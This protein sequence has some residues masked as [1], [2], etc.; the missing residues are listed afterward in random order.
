M[1]RLDFLNRGEQASD[2]ALPLPRFGMGTAAIGN[3]YAPVSDEAAHAAVATALDLGVGYFDTAPYYG[4]GLA[5]RRLGEALGACGGK[6]IVSTK[7]GRLL[8]PVENPDHERH[9][10]VG[11]D[12]FQPRFDYSYDAVLRSH[13]ESLKRL[14]RQRVEILLAHDMGELTHG[15]QADRHM[16]DFLNGGYR[17][18]ADLKASGAID[19]IG[20]GVNETA[21]IEDLLGRVDL[22]V[23]LIA[24]RYTL[25]DQQAADRLFPICESKDVRVIIGGPYNSGILA[26]PNMSRTEARYDYQAAPAEVVARAE[27][28]ERVCER[29]GVPL[30][31]AALQFPSR[32]RAVDCVIAGCGSKREIKEAVERLAMPIGEEYWRAIE[33]QGLVRSGVRAMRE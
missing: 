33:E 18:M 3:L 21:V 11:G 5:E 1:S 29:H 26:Q 17:A 2:P 20:V 30:P 27:A 9:G 10:F 32:H 24:G 23:V 28:I 4:F 13:E 19:A 16:R 31:A 6:A 12:P 7:V 25:L 15:A 22:D 14:R 8:E